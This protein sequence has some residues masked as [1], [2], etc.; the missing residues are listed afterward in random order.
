MEYE[1]KGMS[2]MNSLTRFLCTSLLSISTILAA[3]SLPKSNHTITLGIR[4][5]APQDVLDFV[6]RAFDIAKIDVKFEVLPGER[7]LRESSLGHIDGELHRDVGVMK[8]FNT[9]L[10]INVPIQKYELWVLMNKDDQCPVDV[11]ELYKLKPIGVLGTHYF[12]QIY[13]RSQAGF[14]KAPSIDSIAKMLDLKRGDY[15]VAPDSYTKYYSDQKQFAFK[16]CFDHP[17]MLITTYTYLHE[18]NSHLIKI[19]EKAYSQAKS[20]Q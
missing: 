2:V 5:K 9:L 20:E 6:Q 1:G 19:L 15:T 16:K 17:Y 18:R 3:E 4:E 8:E 13:E 11:A 10:R 7:S 14:Y 12:D